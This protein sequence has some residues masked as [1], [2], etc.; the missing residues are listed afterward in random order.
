MFAVYKPH[1]EFEFFTFKDPSSPTATQ[2]VDTI[3]LTNTVY[4][5]DGRN[6]QQIISSEPFIADPMQA[7]SEL[8]KHG[9]SVFKSKKEAREVGQAAGLGTQIRY[10]EIDFS[11]VGPEFK[12]QL[13]Q[14][15]N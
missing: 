2:I 15:R 12:Y 6:C 13:R 11:Q 10:L 9:V 5:Y 8:Y 4:N 7:M 3:E 14:Q 1:T